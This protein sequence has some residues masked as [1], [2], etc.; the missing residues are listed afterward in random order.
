MLLFVLFFAFATSAMMFVLGQS[1]FADLSDFNRLSDSKRAFLASESLTEDVVYRHVFGTF[2]IDNEESLTL[3]GV[4]AYSTTTYDS[5]SDTFTVETEASVGIVI[6]KSEALLSIGAG[7]SFNYG[8]QAGNGG[9]DLNQ[10]AAVYGNLYSNGQVTGFGSNQSYVYGDIVSAGA[11]GLV[12]DLHATGTVWAHT[13]Q[14]SK[15]EGDAYYMVDGGGNDI[16]GAEDSSAADQSPIGFPLSTTTI[17]KWKDA[18]TDIESVSDPSSV[19]FG[20]GPYEIDI[21]KSIGY[22]KFECDVEVTGNNTDLY[23]TGPIWVEGNLSF[24]NGPNIHADPDLDRMSVQFIVDN[25]ADRETSSQIIIAQS[26]SFEG[27]GDERSFILLFSQNESA[28]LGTGEVAID[29]G[30]SG[31]GDFLAYAASGTVAIG[32]NIELTEVTAYQINISN[33]TD[34]IYKTGLANMLFTSGPGGSYV[35]DDWQQKQ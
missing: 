20:G 35:L 27:S 3:A 5:V 33:N 29:I 13:I 22:T 15:I 14:D 6:R 30:N 8:L 16:D 23:V 4:S 32:Q 9:I 26:T 2:S 10:G 1:I 12:S 31:T 34:V 25:P 28:A 19:C 24:N 7:S 11:T 18:I 17:Q 21:D